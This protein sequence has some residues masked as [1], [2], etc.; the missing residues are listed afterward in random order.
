MKNNPNWMWCKHV[1]NWININVKCYNDRREKGDRIC[2]F[3]G[4]WKREKRVRE[5]V[6]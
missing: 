6:K 2:P 1:E 4:C 5:G 3:K